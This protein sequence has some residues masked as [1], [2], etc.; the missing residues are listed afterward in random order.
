MSLSRRIAAEGLGTA[1]LLAAVVGSGIMGDRL[2]G[3]NVAIALLANTLATA[4][5]LV[6]LILTFGPISGAHF[7]PAVTLAD[8]SQGGVR[9]RD[10]P[11]Y[12]VGAVRRR[13]RWRLCGAPDV[14]RSRSVQ[15]SEHARS[16]AAQMF[17]EFVATF[18]LL[19]VIW[20]C[21]AEAAGRRAVRGRALHHRRVLV[22]GLDL[23]RQS[24]R[25][26]R[27]RV[28]R[29]VRRHS[30]GR[31]ARVRRGPARGSCRGH[32]AVSLARCP[33]PHRPRRTSSWSTNGRP[34]RSPCG[35]RSSATSTATF[36]PSMAT[37]RTSRPS[38]P[39]ACIALAILLG[40]ALI[41]ERSDRPHSPTR[42]PDDHGQL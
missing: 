27:P 36:Q 16:G 13:L 30:A 32:A 28:D 12:L 33:R 35:S 41:A 18:G 14:R 1:L 25:D 9:W 19:S 31:R 23:V 11:G 4:A 39:I 2:A 34:R 42:D 7:N 29:H 21:R 5:T 38:S 26:G 22:H 6:A 17:S 37:L 40:M 20:S 8:A 24:R 15:A 10:V 3:G